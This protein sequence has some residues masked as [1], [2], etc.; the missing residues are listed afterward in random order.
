MQKFRTATK[1][2]NMLMSVTGSCHLRNTVLLKVLYL[3][4]KKIVYKVSL[5][6]TGF[7]N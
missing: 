7:C 3:Q 6:Q 5:V 2:S 4:F 1:L